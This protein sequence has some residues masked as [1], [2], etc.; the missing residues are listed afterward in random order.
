MGFGQIMFNYLRNMK[1]N[2]L[3]IDTYVFNLYELNMNYI[4]EY[5]YQSY[6]IKGNALAYLRSID[7]NCNFIF[8]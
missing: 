5:T 7:P 3:S 8:I 2:D 6:Q 1:V 4:V